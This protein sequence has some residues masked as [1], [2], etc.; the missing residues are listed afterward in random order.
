MKY[1]SCLAAIGLVEAKIAFII[2]DEKIV[3]TV[4]EIGDAV[5]T[6]ALRPEA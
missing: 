4:N 1:L 2:D 6:E 5:Q 3:N